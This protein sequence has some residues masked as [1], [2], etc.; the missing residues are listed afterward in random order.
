MLMIGSAMLWP[1]FL[2]TGGITGT[3]AP[4]SA[5]FPVPTP[6]CLTLEFSR[7]TIGF[8]RKILVNVKSRNYARG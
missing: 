1:H 6:I 3:V 2:N 4:E 8:V 5:R 7:L